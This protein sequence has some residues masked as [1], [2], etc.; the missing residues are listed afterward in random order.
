MDKRI[1]HINKCINPIIICALSKVIFSYSTFSIAHTD[2][3]FKLDK[4]SAMALSKLFITPEKDLEDKKISEVLPESFW[5][6]NF[7]WICQIKSRF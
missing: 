2:K 7:R 3:L 6:T 1:K 5:S 4:Q